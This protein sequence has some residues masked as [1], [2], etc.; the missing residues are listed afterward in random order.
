MAQLIGSGVSATL[1]DAYERAVWSRPDLR[2]QL[3]AQANP[4]AEA[5]KRRQEAERARRKGSSIR[6]GPGNAQVQRKENATVREDI[7]AAYAEVRESRV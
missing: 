6:G 4:Q 2:Q 3:I 7:E 5:D 1:E